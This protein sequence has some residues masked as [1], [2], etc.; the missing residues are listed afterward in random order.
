MSGQIDDL[1]W[2]ADIGAIAILDGTRLLDRD[3]RLR[4]LR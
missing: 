4:V 2:P 3:G 1:G